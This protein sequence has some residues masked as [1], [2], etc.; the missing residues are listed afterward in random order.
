[1][2]LH[3]LDIPNAQLD[4]E[5]LSQWNLTSDQSI[6]RLHSA[7]KVHVLFFRGLPVS[8]RVRDER[9][10]HIC[11]LPERFQVALRHVTKQC[12]ANPQREGMWS[13]YGYR[14][15][16]L[17]EAAEVVVAELDFAIDDEALIEWSSN[18]ASDCEIS[19]VHNVYSVAFLGGSATQEEYL[20]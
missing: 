18:A 9:G 13:F 20:A 12:G 3:Q 6:F 7:A 4:S 17:Q 15:G 16:S 10:E 1:M 2:R 19:L 8:V 5:L 11:N 14:H